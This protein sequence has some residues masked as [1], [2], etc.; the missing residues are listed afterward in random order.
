MTRSLDIRI[1]AARD[2]GFAAWED[3][4][5]IAAFETATSAAIWL[6]NRLRHVDGQVMP[7][8]DPTVEV[9]PNVFNATETVRK[10]GIL[11]RLKNG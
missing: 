5:V 3:G 10:R 8:N 6:E 1:T 2:E 7:R 11:G 4:E 9:F